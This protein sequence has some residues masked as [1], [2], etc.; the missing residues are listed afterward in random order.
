MSTRSLMDQSRN[1]WVSYAEKGTSEELKLG[2]LQRIALA[3]EKMASSYDEIRRRA[4]MYERWY[5]EERGRRAEVERR[6]A[7]LRGA[8]TRMKKARAADGKAQP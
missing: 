6:N 4:E 7:A 2:C 5:N 1:S 3:T 8:I